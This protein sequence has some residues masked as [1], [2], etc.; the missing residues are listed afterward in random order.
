[1]YNRKPFWT[2]EHRLT[3]SRVQHPT[4]NTNELFWDHRYRTEPWLGSGPGSRGVAQAFKSQLLKTVIEHNAVSSIAD[5]GCGDLCW[6]RTDVISPRDLGNVRYCGLDI[7]SVIVDANR[8]RFPTLDFRRYDLLGE[9]LPSGFDLVLC[10]DVL[11]HQTTVKQ[12]TSALR[13]LLAGVQDTALV[14][15]GNTQGS[16]DET[17]LQMGRDIDGKALPKPRHLDLLQEAEFAM[18]RKRARTDR[19]IPDCPTANHGS[20][21]S[22]VNHI[23]PNHRVRHVADYRYQ[24][25]YALDFGRSPLELPGRP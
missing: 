10:F 20:L 15:Y 25:L 2:S 1:M 6:L 16:V 17:T 8:E 7:S 19:M 12:F 24:S 9:P 14:S 4:R 22:W 11:I 13:N 21:P 3:E 18:R 23:S 5:V